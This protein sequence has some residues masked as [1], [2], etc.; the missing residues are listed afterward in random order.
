M[1][2]RILGTATAALLLTIASVSR[3]QV[4]PVPGAVAGGVPTGTATAEPLKLSLV[5]AVR[6]GLDRNLGTILEQQR[7]RSAAANRREALSALLPHLA[8]NVRQSAQVINTA[9][10]G[11]SGFGDLPNIIGPFTVFDARVALST[12]LVD[13]AALAEWRAA[14]STEQAAQADYREM[15]EM[16]VLAVGNLYLQ[17]VADAARL[18][19]ARAQM[20]TADALVK[21]TTDQNAAGVVARID[22][23]RQQVQLEAARSR[24]IAADNQLAKRKLDL[25]RAIGLPPG[26]A[27]ELTDNTGFTPAP[28]MSLDAAL[29]VATA[30]R[31]DVKAARSRVDAARATRRAAVA[32][33]LPS[34]RLDADVGALGLTPHSAERTYTVAA[35]LHVPIFEGGRTQA[36]TLEADAELRQ[37]EAELADVSSGVRYD[38]AAALLDLNAAESAVG[39]ATSGESLAREELTQAED[40]F[41]AGI[42]TSIELVQAQEAVA[43]ASEQYIASVYA[44]NV[45]KAQFA[46]ALGE[47]ES[48]FLALVGGQP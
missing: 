20:A 1:N 30:H 17:A 46:R 35:T 44:H 42:A 3:A 22:V 38:V 14:R 7:T 48:R 37:R 21:L 11:F 40:R 33:N 23:L 36:R 24:E 9:A 8:A 45:A 16:V 19:S 39:V 41:R 15:R 26:Q 6:R 34:L 27:I 18:D 47:G 28:P 4:R 43:R 32:G 25:S 2:A 5:D 10:F 31:D 29:E 13:P 12:P